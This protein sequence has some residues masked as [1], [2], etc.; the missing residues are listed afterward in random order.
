MKVL[1]NQTHQGVSGLITVAL[2][3]LTEANGI[4]KA[5][6]GDPTF[7]PKHWAECQTM[8]KSNKNYGERFKNQN[9]EKN[10]LEECLTQIEQGNPEIVANANKLCDEFVEQAKLIEPSLTLEKTYMPTEE[11]E[12]FDAGKIASDDPMAFFDRQK[13]GNPRSGRGDGAYRILINTDVSWYGDPTVHT[14]ALMAIVILL[15]RNAPVEIWI[16]Q[17]WWGRTHYVAGKGDGITLFKVFSGGVIQP[18]NIWF[19]IGSP[20]KDIPYSW[21]VNKMIG[22]TNN[23][24]SLDPEIP[25]DLYIYGHRMPDLKSADFAEWIAFT[26]RQM[27][28][29]EELPENWSG[30]QNEMPK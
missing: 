4:V 15:Q 27:L 13:E 28:F 21:V 1:T 8:L 7:L 9:L 6:L 19:W 20:Y 25:C 10:T 2:D 29:D 24:V 11:G 18:Q 26:S 12:I 22:R 14:A 3:G 16:Q 17:G 23:S 5:A 30:Y